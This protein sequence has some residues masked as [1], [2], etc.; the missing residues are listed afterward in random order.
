M[1]NVVTCNS[2]ETDSISVLGPAADAQMEI[3]TYEACL[4]VVQPHLWQSHYQRRFRPSLWSLSTPCKSSVHLWVENSVLCFWGWEIE[5]GFLC[6]TG[7]PP[8]PTPQLL[9]FSWNSLCL[10][11]SGVKGM[12]H[13]CL[14]DYIT[15]QWWFFSFFLGGHKLLFFFCH[16]SQN[17]KQLNG[18]YCYCQWYLTE[19]SKA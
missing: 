2:L 8:Y 9:W 15:L 1:W 16:K 11:G 7:C 12:C 4:W 17:S 18:I 6:I 10:L 3:L 19:T 5:T 13:H 14:A